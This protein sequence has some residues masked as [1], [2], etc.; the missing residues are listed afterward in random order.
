MSEE[1]E[2]TK[3]SNLE[4]KVCVTGM[5]IFK[6]IIDV[7]VKILNDEKIPRELLEPHIQHFLKSLNN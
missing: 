3:V 6:N 5:S 1:K 4:I 2:K 7:L